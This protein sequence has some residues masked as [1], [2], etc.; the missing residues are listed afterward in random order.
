LRHPCKFQRVSHFG[1]V[2]A[3]HLVVGHLCS[4]GRPSGWA[5][6]HILVLF[7]FVCFFC[8]HC[9]RLQISQR[10]TKIRR[11][12]SVCVGLLSG[13]VFSPFGE[14]WLAGSHGGG[15]ITSECAIRTRRAV[16]TQRV[17][18]GG[19]LQRRSVG[20]GNWGRRRCLRPYG[21][22]CVLQAC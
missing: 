5:L 3:W 7:V 16:V 12:F 9:I 13:H 4:A 22:I 15:A 8:L 18:M 6:A 11:E 21:G 14:L 20:I 2:T 19:H 1:S 10:W 17:L